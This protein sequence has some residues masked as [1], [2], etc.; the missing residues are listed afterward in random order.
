MSNNSASRLRRPVTNTDEGALV[1]LL[2]ELSEKATPG[3]WRAQPE[4]VYVNG[5]PGPIMS[6]LVGDRSSGEGLK[7]RLASERHADH[8]LVVALVNAWRSGKLYVTTEAD[9]YARRH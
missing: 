1:G 6:Y 5:R 8:A 7:V 9:D 2:N 4:R 3:P